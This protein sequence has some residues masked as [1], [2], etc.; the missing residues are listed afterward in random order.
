ME[1]PI[2]TYIVKELDQSIVYNFRG[3]AYKNKG[4][5]DKA[6]EDFKKVLELNDDVELSQ[7]AQKPLQELGIK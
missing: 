3:N 7:K 5:K 1:P 2:T 6:Q 4:R